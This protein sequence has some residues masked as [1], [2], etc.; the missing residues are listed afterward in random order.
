MEEINKNVYEIIEAAA[1]LIQ[2]C[3]R[4]YRTRKIIREHLRH[5]LVQEMINN[6]DGID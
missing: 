2:K 6:V 5:L 1:I 4:G 3:W